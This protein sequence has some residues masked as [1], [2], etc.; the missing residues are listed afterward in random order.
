M[1][2]D[3]NRDTTI[4]ALDAAIQYDTAVFNQPTFTGDF[5]TGMI[6]DSQGNAWAGHPDGYHYSKFALTGG[7]E[8]TD[9]PTAI[10]EL[11]FILKPDAPVGPATIQYVGGF[12]GFSDVGGDFL[13]SHQQA[14]FTIEAAPHR[15]TDAAADVDAYRDAD[16][17]ADAYADTDPFP[18]RDTHVHPHRNTDLDADR[19]AHVDADRDAHVD[20]D[21]DAHGHAHLDA[22]A[23]IDADVHG[24]IDTD[25]DTHRYAHRDPH[26]TP[27]DSPTET[28][29]LSPTLTPTPT[30]SPTSSPTSTA[31]STPTSTPTATPTLT[32]TATSTPATLLDCSGFV[33]MYCGVLYAGDTTGQDQ[34]VSDYGCIG[35][36]ESGPEV[37][38]RF[39]TTATDDIIVSLTYDLEID[40]D[41]VPVGFVR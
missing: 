37:V 33:Q 7:W 31:T 19:D 32:P 4:I 1:M 27:T 38:H 21:R 20:A 24:D 30:S 18:H 16:L 41:P 34:N 40:L 29:T 39:T 2:V 11:T 8:V 3:P 14:S 28:P 25:G 13:D 26:P 36:D 12:I 17:D 35:W 9:T 5:V 6:D 22:D 23:D 10:Y 15:D